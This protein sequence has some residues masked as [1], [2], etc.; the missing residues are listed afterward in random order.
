MSTKESTAAAKLR[1]AATRRISSRAL[2][3]LP[4]STP[5]SAPCW[6]RGTR[7]NS[8]VTSPF[9]RAEVIA[10]ARAPR[11]VLAGSDVTAVPSRL[12]NSVPSRAIPVAMPTWRKVEL[13]PEAIPARCGCTT[14]TA[15]DASG[16]LTSPMPMPETMR[17]GMRWVQDEVASR[18]RISTSPTPMRARPGPINTRI[19]TREVR[20]PA[21]PLT[22]RMAP[23]R[24]SRPRPVC[25]AL[26]CSTSWR[27][28]T[29]YKSIE[30]MP[31]DIPKAAMAPPEKVGRRNSERSNIACSLRA[32]STTKLASCSFYAGDYRTTQAGPQRLKSTRTSRVQGLYWECKSDQKLAISALTRAGE[33]DANSPRMQVLLGR[34]EEHTSELQSLRHLVCRLL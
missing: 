31:A 13:I 2:V 11:G 9:L 32:S 19:G 16:G 27:Y 1:M 12:L 28:S 10:P 21:A 3:K 24:S 25:S 7:W 14:P 30:K 22:A 29:R 34:S 5:T 26:Y 17:P 33:I 6:L 8:W 18:P 20:C 4:L 23:E 15:V